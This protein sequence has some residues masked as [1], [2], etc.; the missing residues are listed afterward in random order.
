MTELGVWADA[1]RFVQVLTVVGLAVGTLAAI[2]FSR[3]D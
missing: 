2:V 3:D 1:V